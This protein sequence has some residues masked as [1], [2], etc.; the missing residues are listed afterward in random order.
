[1]M[2]CE[3]KGGCGIFRL[4][5]KTGSASWPNGAEAQFL[6]ERLD[7]DSLV[8]RRT[9]PP[10]STVPGLSGLYLGKLDGSHASGTVAWSWHG[11]ETHGVWSAVTNL[12][13]ISALTVHR[14]PSRTGDGHRAV[15]PAL[16]DLNGTWET[17]KVIGDRFYYDLAFQIEQ[18]EGAIRVLD[19]TPNH[20]ASPTYAEL[21]HGTYAPR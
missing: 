9:D 8:I 7:K 11:G 6:I 3:G 15:P 14:T 20:G 2:E 21:F 10:I 5:G 19:A 13:E 16:A 17:T 4:N 12:T 1:M 18:K